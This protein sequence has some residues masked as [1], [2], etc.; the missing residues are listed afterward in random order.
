MR[1]LQEMFSFQVEITHL[2]VFVDCDTPDMVFSQPLS[3]C[4]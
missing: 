1:E 2:L 4:T 3:G